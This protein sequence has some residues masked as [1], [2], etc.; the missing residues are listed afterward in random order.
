MLQRHEG[1]ERR[2]YQDTHGNWTGG[3]GRNLTTVE[4]SESEIDLMLTNDIN[5]AYLD[6]QK[7]L[8]DL[9]KYP[10]VIINVLIDMHINLGSGGIRKFKKMLNAVR[11]LNWP[12]MRKELLDSEA[13]REL[14]CRYNDLANLID[15]VGGGANG[16]KE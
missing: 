5:A 9:L 14:P 16:K 2:I 4:F 8:P 1:R 13:A 12:E 11:M 7:L 6:L 15:S 10:I 3:V